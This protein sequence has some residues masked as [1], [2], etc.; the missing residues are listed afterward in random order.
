MKRVRKPIRC[1]PKPIFYNKLYLSFGEICL[2]ASASNAAHDKYLEK[3]Q[4]LL[5]NV[6]NNVILEMIIIL[7]KKHIELGQ[8]A[9]EVCY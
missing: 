2:E 7:T 1:S 6:S 8:D 4:K 5:K 9:P 3:V